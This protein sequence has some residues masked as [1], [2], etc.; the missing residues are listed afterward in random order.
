LYNS[1]QTCTAGSLAAGH[2]DS[3]PVRRLR[4]TDKDLVLLSHLHSFSDWVVTFDRDLGP[5]IFDQPSGQNEIPYLLDYIP[6]EELSGISSYLTTKPSTEIFGLLGPHFEAFNI[7]VT[8]EEGQDTIKTILEDI[9]SV[10]ASLVMQLNS[11]ENRAFEAIGMAFSKRV[12]EKKSL[13]QNAF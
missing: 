8:T 5:Q 6:G 3:V 7:N 13:L 4:L 9:R 10:S 2:T 1:F 11:S 12:L